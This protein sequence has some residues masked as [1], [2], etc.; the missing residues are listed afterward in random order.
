[1]TPSWELEI[2]ELKD[3]EKWKIELIKELGRSRKH[4]VDIDLD[5]DQLNFIL[6]QVCLE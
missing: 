5:E 1:M 6:D 4:L 3:E 2:Q